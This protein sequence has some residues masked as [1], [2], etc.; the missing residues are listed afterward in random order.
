MKKDYL[1][2]EVLQVVITENILT[3]TD[4]GAGDG[5]SGD[6]FPKEV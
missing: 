3:T 1:K 4:S 5:T 6:I 2:P